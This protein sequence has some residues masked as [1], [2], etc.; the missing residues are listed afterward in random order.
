MQRKKS[1]PNISLCV[2]KIL[3]MNII[4]L[5]NEFLW[6]FLI[7]IMIILLPL[8]VTGPLESVMCDVIKRRDATY[9]KPILKLGLPNFRGSFYLILLLAASLL[10]D[11]IYD[12]TH[13]AFQ[14]FL[15]IN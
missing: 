4:D 5:N 8:L 11:L 14:R 6:C 12:V 15:V 7:L 2:K 1:L 3:I 13:D 10:L 9:F